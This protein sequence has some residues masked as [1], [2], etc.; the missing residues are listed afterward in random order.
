MHRLYEVGRN[1]GLA[2]A[3]FIEVSVVVLRAVGAVVVGRREVLEDLL[4]ETLVRS[5]TGFWAVILFYQP[6]MLRLIAFL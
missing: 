5:G 1:T 4:G 6:K 2:L 3:R